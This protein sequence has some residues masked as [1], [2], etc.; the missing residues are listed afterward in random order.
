MLPAH[1]WSQ[2]MS[3]KKE[4]FYIGY[5]SQ[6]PHWVKR[7]FLRVLV[8]LGIG[9]FLFIFF[10]VKEQKPFYPSVWEMNRY[11]TF[12]GIVQER[13]VPHLLIKRPGVIGDHF[14]YSQYY[15]FAFGKFGAQ[16]AVRGL[17]GKRVTLEG[18]LLYRDDQTAI[19]LKKGSLQISKETPPQENI[20]LPVR[21]LG[22]Y[23]FIGEIVDSKCYLGAMKPGESK[24]HRS[25]AIR[26]ISG[27]MPPML[28]TQ[29]K[30]GREVI[31]Y[32]LLSRIGSRVNNRLLEFVGRPVSIE[33]W[34]ETH[35]EMKIL[36]ADPETDYA[37]LKTR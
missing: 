21:S 36:K 28:V 37:F 29:D 31:Y 4:S 12:T 24:I 11:R 32:V 23:R 30:R 20:Q 16:E 3:N 9:L 17:H 5:Q 25:C 22:R 26:C 19:E 34:V 35:G 15:L 8:P 10:V 27:G 18:A 6:A 1:L 7:W 2:P 13:P 33:G 14:S